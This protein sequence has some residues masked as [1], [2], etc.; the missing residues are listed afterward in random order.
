MSTTFQ[1]E[2]PKPRPAER[3]RQKKTFASALADI[4]PSIEADVEMLRKLLQQSGVKCAGR[5]V[6]IPRRQD[7]EGLFVIGEETRPTP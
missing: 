7:Q 2:N 4:L 3:V 5:V 6:S 1:P